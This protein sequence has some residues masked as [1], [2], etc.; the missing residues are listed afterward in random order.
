MDQNFKGVCEMFLGNYCRGIRCLLKE[1]KFFPSSTHTLT[2]NV[3][4]RS[5]EVYILSSHTML[6]VAG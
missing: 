2:C 3:L 5:P 4:C 6:Y 1:L